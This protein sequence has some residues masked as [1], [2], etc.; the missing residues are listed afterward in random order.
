MNDEIR[1]S[2]CSD[3][4]STHNVTS[5]CEQLSHIL[6]NVFNRHA[7]IIKKRLKGKPAPWLNPNNKA[8][9]NERD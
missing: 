4:Y 2:D 1:S 7:P 5:M 3:I 6:R 9:M 8:A